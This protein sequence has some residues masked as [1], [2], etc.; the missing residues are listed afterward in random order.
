MN[1]NHFPSP[2]ES[3]RVPLLAA[4]LTVAAIMAG[5]LL[6]YEPVGHDPDR[7]YRPIKTE[8]AAKLRQGTLPFW[9]AKIGLGIPLVAESH[10][11][12]FYPP[13]WLLYSICDVSTAY[14]ISM[15]LHY[16]ALAAAFFAYARQMGASPWGAAI[17]AVAFTLCGFQTAHASHEWAYHALPF[18]PLCLLAGDK[19]ATTG[20]WK[21]VGVLGLLWGV[22]IT[23]GHF[24]LQMWTG[25]LVLFAGFWRLWQDRLPVR[26]VIGLVVGVILGMGLALVQLVPSFE[27]ARVV[28][29]FQRPV[30]QLV[31]SSYPLDHW[32]E[33]AVPALFRNL[34]GG[35]GG[36]GAQYWNSQQVFG[37]D[38]LYVGTIPLIL[39]IL[40][41]IRATAAKARSSPGG[42]FWFV[43]VVVTLALATMPRWWPAGYVS[44]LHV[45]GFGL[46]R[47]PARYTVITSFALCMLAGQ[48]FDRVLDGNRFRRG[49]A[50]AGFYAAIS[51][52]WSFILPRIR[53]E[54]R[55]ALDDAAISGRVGLA[56]V[57]WLAATI[58][59]VVWRRSPRYAAV[60]FTA[61]A[62]E[63][64]AFYM[65]AGTAGWARPVRLPEASPVLDLLAKE[66]ASSRVSGPLD[67]L[68]VRV[69]LV[70]GS[71][72]TGFT[73]P[74]PNALLQALHPHNPNSIRWLRRFGVTH[75]VF[76]GPLPT[77]DFE[78]VFHGEDRVLDEL[79]YQTPGVSN[80][81]D[82]RV[83][84]VREVFPEVRLAMRAREAPELAGL[85][86]A[87]SSRDAADEAWFI[88]GNTPPAAT[89][90]AKTARIIHWDGLSGAVEHDG[91]ID[92]VLCHAFYPGWEVT[93]NNAPSRPALQSNGGLLTARLGGDGTSQVS[94]RYR[95][96]GMKIAMAASGV[97]IFLCLG[98]IRGRKSSGGAAA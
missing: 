28:G 93:I 41:A 95:P 76:D 42:A 15:W 18:L 23:I 63:L 91:A 92:L 19:F 38:F 88:S 32:S 79:A 17:T 59:L 97:S 12:A 90:R 56:V 89:Y 86:A 64:G 11:A 51:F 65:F 10:V 84:R 87:L 71:P 74:M 6:R 49:L 53:P 69:G 70:A 55:L 50:I 25:G 26:R 68:P 60:L 61:T 33:P 73:L 13:N 36:P 52:V 45:P 3:S 35:S 94:F 58:L 31:A 40:G 98:L 44:L 22:Q 7:L 47:C 4:S 20:R 67:D 85:F 82:W 16:V 77:R 96:R 80:Q 5:L 21:W 37:F 14:R 66:P 2:F 43:L 24:Q 62:V 78:E 34:P 39:A 48:G 27:L 57:T 83:F 8:L 81:R 30:E 54:F 9:S 46:F 75:L 72:Y 1:E 29:Q